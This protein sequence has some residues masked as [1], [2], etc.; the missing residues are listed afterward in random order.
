MS[1]F[2]IAYS[3]EAR[4][5]S[6]A[7]SV[8]RFTRGCVI[9]LFPLYLTGL[10]IGL[11]YA[12]LRTT[13]DHDWG[14]LGTSIA[15]A[16]AASALLVPMTSVDWAGGVFPFN[17]PVDIG[18]RVLG[19]HPICRSRHP[20][21]PAYAGPRARWLLRRQ[22]RADL[23]RRRFLN[24]LAAGVSWRRSRA[25]RVLVF[26]R[27]ASA[28]EPCMERQRGLQLSGRLGG[29]YLE[30]QREPPERLCCANPVGFPL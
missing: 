20:A 30:P 7:L 14:E 23:E 24:W 16:T 9:R 6:G 11:A 29:H 21:R 13:L 8:L 27:R 15:G 2:V 18:L 5:K 3:Y 10:V 1:G 26:S 4:L 17:I 12:V 22:G 25:F 28:R 19:H